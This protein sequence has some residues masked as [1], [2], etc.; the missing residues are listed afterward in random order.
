MLVVPFGDLLLHG[1]RDDNLVVPGNQVAR[2]VG[3]LVTLRGVQ[4]LLFGAPKYSE[5]VFFYKYQK[6]SE[7]KKLWLSC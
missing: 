7:S 1:F 4:V 6:T 3:E 2:H 5:I